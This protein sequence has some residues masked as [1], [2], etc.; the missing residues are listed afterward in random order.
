MRNVMDH[1]VVA[2]LQEGG[3][4]RAERLVAF[5]RKA[6]SE[7]NGMLLGD[8]DI[9]TVR[10]GKEVRCSLSRPVPEGM[11]AVMPTILSS[12]RASCTSVSPNTDV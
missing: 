12:R 5:R 4:E 10:L 1:L 9:E 8:A 11:A 3:I 2:A 6:C 7:G